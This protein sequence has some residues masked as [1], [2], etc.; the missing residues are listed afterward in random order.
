MVQLN[1]NADEHEPSGDYEAMPEGEYIAKI[2]KSDIV[3]LDE[4]R[5]YLELEH[6]IVGPTHAGRKIT[7]NVWRKHTNPKAVNV[8]NGQLSS[9]CR[10]V[11]I[12]NVGDSVQF[13]NI[14]VKVRVKVKKGQGTY[15][16]KSGE[17]KPAKDQNEITSWSPR[18]RGA[19]PAQAPQAPPYAREA[20]ADD[21]F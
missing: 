2:V 10:A 5:V 13:H 8:G 12:M 3:K 16:D 17:T 11:G 7:E 20:S 6:E 21:D 19:A 1:F 4:D 15:I 9:I 18:D 14:P